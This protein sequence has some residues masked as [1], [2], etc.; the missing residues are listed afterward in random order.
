VIQQLLVQFC[1]RLACG[2][3][4]MM[5]CTSSRSVGIQYFRTLMLVV[6][7]LA[8][9]GLMAGPGVLHMP[10]PLL[11]LGAI[12]SFFGFVV[13]TLGRL[14]AGKWT[15]A[16]LL[17][18]MSGSLMLPWPPGGA[19]SL[20]EVSLELAGAVASAALLGS[21]MAAMLLG[22]SYLV[23]PAMSMDPL[24]K[25]VVLMGASLG[26]RAIVDGISL[27]LVWQRSGSDSAI[28]SPGVFW[29]SLLAARWL[30]GLI[31]PAIIA[32]MVWQTARIRS[33][34]SATGILYVGVFL[35]FF[36]EVTVQILAIRSG[37]PL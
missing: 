25:L 21:M 10:G 17:G 2:L 36:G 11:L 16:V 1:I 28:H 14:T 26:C 7:G 6:L 20:S 4:C 24:K 27:F 22:H 35:T 3:S 5:V 19:T 34:Q 37:P 9:L 18:C 23:A 8:V 12:A 29:W 30:I 33:T 31:G 32:W 15:A 13:W